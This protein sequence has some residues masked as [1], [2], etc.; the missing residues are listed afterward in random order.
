MELNIK[1]ELSY[2]DFMAKVDADNVNQ[3]TLCLSSTATRYP[4]NIT[5][6]EPMVSLGDT[7]GNGPR[8]VGQLREKSVLINVKEIRSGDRTLVL[9]N[10]APLIL[11]VGFCLF[12][13]RQMRGNANGL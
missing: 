12:L 3:V 6:G 13:M 1:D 8:L 7:Q 5:A 9:L 10:A 11:L 4:E 2:S